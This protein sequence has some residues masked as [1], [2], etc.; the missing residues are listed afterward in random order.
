MRKISKSLV[1]SIT[2]FMVACDQPPDFVVIERQNYSS[3][4]DEINANS[5][6]V[7]RSMESASIDQRAYF[8]QLE[9]LEAKRNVTHSVIGWGSAAYLH[10]TPTGNWRGEI[11]SFHMPEGTFARSISVEQNIDSPQFFET[12]VSIDPADKTLE[13]LTWDIVASFIDLSYRPEE[14]ETKITSF[15]DPTIRYYGDQSVA[16]LNSYLNYLT[17]H[18]N[19]RGP[20][21]VKSIAVQADLVAVVSEHELNTG[22]QLPRMNRV[23]EIFQIKNGLIIAHWSIKQN[24]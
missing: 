15:V 6:T 8:D 24:Q 5:I 20:S 21:V 13:F 7:Q 14:L 9:D 18:N 16:G 12:L 10:K 23:F 3:T 19:R 4:D 1:S 11:H 2:L 22:S 17:T